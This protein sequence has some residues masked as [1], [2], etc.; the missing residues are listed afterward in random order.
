MQLGPES[1]LER[2]R[3]LN[4]EVAQE[5]LTSL[6]RSLLVRAKDGVLTLPA[7]ADH[8]LLRCGVLISSP[9]FFE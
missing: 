7:S 8:A 3:K 5:R 4:N 9:M 2:L 1:D 6:D